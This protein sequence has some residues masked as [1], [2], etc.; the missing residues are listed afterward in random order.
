MSPTA[1]TLSPLTTY[2]PNG[3]LSTPADLENTLS[4]HSSNIKLVAWSNPLS[5][6]TIVRPSFVIT[7]TVAVC[8]RER[9]ERVA[10]GWGG[11]GGAAAVSE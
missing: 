4:W 6:P 2:N 9:G 5:V 1:A 11:G 3:T 10:G 7:I 8:L